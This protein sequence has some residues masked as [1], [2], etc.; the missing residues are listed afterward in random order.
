VIFVTV[1]V[2]SFNLTI[3]GLVIVK[4]VQNVTGDVMSTN[5]ELNKDWE[6]FC[7]DHIRSWK[8]DN[9]QATSGDDEHRKR[10]MAYFKPLGEAWLK[11]RGYRPIW[12][13]DPTVPTI[14]MEI[15]NHDND[16]GEGLV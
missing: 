5:F 8:R 1:L 13:D 14:R 15:I 4:H 3:V 2:N 10:F 9:P 6:A 11:E 7:R 12:D 16:Q